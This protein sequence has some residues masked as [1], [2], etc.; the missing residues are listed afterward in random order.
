MQAALPKQYLSLFGRRVISHSL[1]CLC[2]YPAVHGVMIG[3]ATD[4]VH[5]PALASE[6]RCLP[7][8]LGVSE[9]GETRADT[10]RNGLIALARHAAPQ[11]WILVHDAVR[12]CLRH[13]DIDR[14]VKAVANHDDGGL[15]AL[16][17]SDTVKR[18]D[19]RGR[20]VETVLRTGL[21]RAQTPQMFRL[22]ALLTALERARAAGIE[23]TD[24]ASAIEMNGG[25]P[26]VVEGRA[27]N[28]KITVPEDLAM[29]EMFLNQQEQT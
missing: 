17:I 21:W 1:E 16:P 5:W 22:G 28:I 10:V 12:P 9:A 13:T 2:R 25:S 7:K 29:A 14:L 19:N 3:I 23:I 15:L 26:C 8:F 20:V 24:E 4:D 6:F 18:T 11:D 27:D